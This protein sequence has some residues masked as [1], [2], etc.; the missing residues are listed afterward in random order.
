MPK[1]YASTL[2]SCSLIP[3]GQDYQYTK[4]AVVASDPILMN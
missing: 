4:I 1:A 3:P 2:A